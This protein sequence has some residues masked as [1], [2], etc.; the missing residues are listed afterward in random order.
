[1]KVTN[2]AARLR[3]RVFLTNSFLVLFLVSCSLPGRSSGSEAEQEARK[4]WERWL[5]KCGD[6]YVWRD[7]PPPNPI[8]NLPGYRPFRYDHD[9]KSARIEVTQYEVQQADKLNGI[10]W[11][12][13][14]KPNFTA[15]RRRLVANGQW[16]NWA[17]NQPPYDGTFKDFEALPL[18]KK[19]GQWIFP[20]ADYE[21]A[22]SKNLT[23]ID[24]GDVAK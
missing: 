4:H 19:N 16:S 3:W 8:P 14:A 10:E 12:G 22:I 17:G 21:S 5:T 1:M 6:S 18:E 20:R 24:C 9:C 15:C 13:T 23:K 7:A 2:F 11:K